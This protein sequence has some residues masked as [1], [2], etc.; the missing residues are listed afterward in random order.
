MQLSGD[1]EAEPRR[2]SG[3]NGKGDPPVPIPNTEV[4]P[5]SAESTWLETAREDRSLP[6]S[7]TSY[8]KVWG[9]FL[10]SGRA[11]SGKRRETEREEAGRDEAEGKRERD[12]A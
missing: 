6:D 5:L 4:K 1:A 11:K 3:G 2:I 9:V 12:V 10:C 7:N 8:R